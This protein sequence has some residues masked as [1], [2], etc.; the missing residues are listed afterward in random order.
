M[1]R[2]EPG[3]PVYAFAQPDGSSVVLDLSVPDAL[4]DFAMTMRL[5]DGRDR[6]GSV[7]HSGEPRLFVA[8]LRCW[9]YAATPREIATGIDWIRQELKTTTKNL[10]ATTKSENNFDHDLRAIAEI[11][12]GVDI[13]EESRHCSEGASYITLI[14]DAAGLTLMLENSDLRRQAAA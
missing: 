8:L 9:A 10:E 2:L 12:K 6:H 4:G 1:E 13:V 3:A 11:G 7:Y 5:P 14:P